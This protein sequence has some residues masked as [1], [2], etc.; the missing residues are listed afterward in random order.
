MRKVGLVG[1]TFLMAVV[2]QSLDTGLCDHPNTFPVFF[3]FSFSEKP[4]EFL[5]NFN[6]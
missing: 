6:L 3:L 1:S 5:L 4:F 2:K